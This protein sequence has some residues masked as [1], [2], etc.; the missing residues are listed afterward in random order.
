MYKK[1]GLRPRIREWRDR[2]ASEY[3]IK[4]I[5]FFGDF[6]TYG[7]RSEIPRIRE[8][9]NLVIETQNT[10]PHYK[11]DF[12]DFIMLDYIYQKALVSAD[13]GVGTFIIF[14]GDGHFSSV[15][16][17]LVDK[18]E[19][20]VLIYA[21][22]E[23]LSGML[24]NVATK[25]VEVPEDGEL[26]HTY[27]SMIVYHV[28]ELKKRFGDA[29]D[30]APSFTS[31]INT[32][33]DIYGIERETVKDIANTMADRGYLRINIRRVGSGRHISTVSVNY[34]K[35]N[36]DGVRLITDTSLFVIPQ[37]ND[38]KNQEPQQIEKQKQ[39]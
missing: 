22:R 21:V 36:S 2:I 19:K 16:K 34:D 5:L 23:G 39:R 15:V 3:N 37:K 29:S 35:L 4:E 38:R 11:K 20:K 12:T 30:K 33:S 32:V 26:E 27:Y 25:C 9:T 10:S 18:C 7:M 13:N 31:V 28:N 6:S 24:K 14:T 1:Y 8:V 17:F